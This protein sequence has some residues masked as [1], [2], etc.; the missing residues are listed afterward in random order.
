MAAGDGADAGERSWR[1][2]ADE[3]L[4]RLH[5]LLFGAELALE[6]GD[7]AMAQILSLRLIGFLD[8][9]TLSSIDAAYI[10]PI[11]A[12]ASSKLVSA[13]RALASDADR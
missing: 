13:S 4:K 12:D 11:R 5:S 3:R 2:D 6:R 8:S 1:G 7:P 9:K 10:A